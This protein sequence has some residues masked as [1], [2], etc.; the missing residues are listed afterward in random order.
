MALEFTT[1]YV[2]DA[3]SIFRYYKRL[4][5]RAMEQVTDEQL[6]AFLDREANSIAIIVKHMAGNMRSRWTDF[7][8]TDGE[9]PNRDR[10]SEFVDPPATRSDVLAAWE[11]G[12]NRLFTALEPLTDADLGRTVA[13]R[14]E[15][16][17]VMQAIN[18][19]LAHYPH[20][21]GQIVLLA[22]HFACDRW[23]SLSVPRNK[24]AEFNRKVAAEELSQ[25]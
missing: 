19:Q 5:D 23:Q 6:F 14:G 20:H 17:S 25:R 12:W 4:A 2:Q 1:S 11:D 16:H 8:T 7:L 10:D 24:S 13:I 21:V 15:A 9:K 18:R 22:K 3:L